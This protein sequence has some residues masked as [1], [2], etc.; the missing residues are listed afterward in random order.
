[1]SRT[2]S[3]LQGV[4]LEPDL[5]EDRE[6]VVEHLVDDLVEQEPR[7]LRHVV[8]ARVVARFAPRPQGGDRLERLLRD[9]DEQPGADEDV[10]LSGLEASRA[11][12]EAG[13]VQHQ[14]HVAVV[15]IDLRP[16]APSREHVLEVERVELVV[17]RQ[18]R[19]F[20]LGGLL[21]V[22][23]GEAVG[24]EALYVRPVALRGEQRGGRPLG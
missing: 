12:V 7:T 24:L 14:E 13:E 16:L 5:V 20:G 3:V 17:L 15:L 18:P 19:R 6:A 23:P 9:G 22:Q 2:S 8:E 21:D 10:Q 4:Q 1:M 11:L